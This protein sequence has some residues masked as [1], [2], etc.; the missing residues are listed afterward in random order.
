VNAWR[1]NRRQVLAGAGAGAALAGSAFI[2]RHPD[3]AGGDTA[4]ERAGT[5]VIL[6]DPRH[7]LPEDVIRRLGGN[8][9]RV[10]GLETDPVRQWRG[11]AAA[12]LA[13]RD[14]R[15]LGVTRWPQ[16]LLV[17]GLAEESG[18][19]VRHQQLNAVSGAITWLIA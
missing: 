5:T 13:A 12:L 8:G 15:L 17:R 1:A 18:R 4:A 9:A 14:T 16:F 10:I 19:R 11:E 7:A 6:Q 2:P 3:N